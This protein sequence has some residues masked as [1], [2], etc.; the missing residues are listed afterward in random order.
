MV[1][2]HWTPTHV[3][4]KSVERRLYTVYASSCA[5]EKKFHARSS[6]YNHSYRMLFI[7]LC[8]GNIMISVDYL[9]RYGCKRSIIYGSFAFRQR[10]IVR[11]VYTSLENDPES[12][13]T[14]KQIFFRRENL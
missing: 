12:E 2:G 4:T 10:A 1:T 11:Y 8:P 6:R 13:W 3:A 5:V 9:N 14:V 7:Q